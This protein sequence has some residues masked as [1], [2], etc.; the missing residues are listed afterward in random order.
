VVFRQRLPEVR[1]ALDP[2]LDQV[3]AV[4]GR[5]HSGLG[6]PRLHE[7]EHGS[8]AQDVLENDSIWP[9]LHV[10]FAA[11]EVGVG[12]IIKM[13]QEDFLGQ[14]HWPAQTLAYCAQGAVHALVHTG[15]KLRRGFYRD[16]VLIPLGTRTAIKAQADPGTIHRGLVPPKP[17]SSCR[18]AG[19]LSM[20]LVYRALS[21]YS[22]YTVHTVALASREA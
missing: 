11:F 9:E 12:G 4:D 15:D 10:A 22:L 8:L 20:V 18:R 2:R 17:L 19:R 5:G 7:L 21:R 6:A 13:R 14:S 16:H 3:V 1:L